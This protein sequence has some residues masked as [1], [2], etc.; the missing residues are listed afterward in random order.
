MQA[1]RALRRGAEQYEPVAR[2]DA[3]ADQ[4]AELAQPARARLGLRH[5]HDEG[6]AGMPARLLGL[7][8]GAAARD[9]RVAG[10][11][12]HRLGADRDVHEV[13][14]VADVLR[15]DARAAHQVAVVG[16]VGVRVRDERAQLRLPVRG[17]PFGRPPAAR[18]QAAELERLA[19]HAASILE[20]KLLTL[21]LGSRG[22]SSTVAIATAAAGPKR[23]TNTARIAS[24]VRRAIAHRDH[25]E[26]E[27]VEVELLDADLSHAGD[28]LQRAEQHDRGH[29][30]AVRPRDEIVEAAVDAE[31]QRERA[32]AGTGTGARRHEVAEPVVDD[33]GRAVHEIGEDE[34]A[35]FARGDVCAPRVHHAE[36]D[37]VRGDV[38]AVPLLAFEPDAQRLHR[39]VGADHRDAEVLLDQRAVA[40]RHGVAAIGDRARPHRRRAGVVDPAVERAEVRP[41]A[42]DHRGPER[43]QPREQFR[44]GEVGRGAQAHQLDA[45]GGEGARLD[46]RADLRAGGDR[47]VDDR[48]AVAR[49]AAD[50]GCQREALAAAGRERL[51]DRPTIVSQAATQARGAARLERQAVAR[52]RAR[53]RE[54]VGMER[55]L[56]LVDE[57][58]LA[59]VAG[60]TDVVRLRGRAT[61]CR[62][63]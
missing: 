28:R 35:A 57:R 15:P 27:A 51:E 18:Q 63:R 1:P 59:Q 4:H 21:P 56:E 36:R 40:R 6:H 25:L 60:A 49:L 7:E 17:E 9:H 38:E 61:A 24:L 46:E 12:Q 13:G 19:D 16:H 62:S 10:V 30:R 44:E 48:L 41:D 22:R 52:V 32:A 14:E 43:V 33:H 31:D 5:A 54:A 23:S 53:R 37:L 2:A 26:V 39:L 55:E 42:A 45:R 20:A 47:P 8:V 50:E 34:L 11:A 29:A 58:Q 3:H